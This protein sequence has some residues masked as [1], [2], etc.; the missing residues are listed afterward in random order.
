MRQKL[1]ELGVGTKISIC[2][3][4]KKVGKSGVILLTDIINA[5]TKELLC[6]HL[7]LKKYKVP[8]NKEHNDFVV[9]VGTI[10]TYQK[11]IGY[12]YNID[13]IKIVLIKPLVFH[14][15]IVYMIST[16]EYQTQFWIYSNMRG[17]ESDMFYDFETNEILHL[18]TGSDDEKGYEIISETDCYY[19]LC[20]AYRGSNLR[21]Y[22]TFDA[23]LSKIKS[24]EET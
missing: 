3:Q 19:N 4:Y 6:D 10:C 9:V 12:D 21:V 2:G 16:E 24:I 22:K 20:Y 17:Y 14:D 11:N 8:W 7:W 23:A 15:T 1:K 18:F 13:P 5:N